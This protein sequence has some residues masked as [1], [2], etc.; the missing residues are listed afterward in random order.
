MAG[1]TWEKTASGRFTPAGEARNQRSKE[2]RTNAVGFKG[3]TR[4]GITSKN[5]NGKISNAQAQKAIKNGD[6]VKMNVKGKEETVQV[7]KAN[8]DAVIKNL[9]ANEASSRTTNFLV[10]AG[11]AGQAGAKEYKGTTKVYRGTADNPKVTSRGSERGTRKTN[12]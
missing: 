9:T 11:R 2:P 4:L 8:R 5:P 7:T 6:K 12:K 10:N 1:R 3:E